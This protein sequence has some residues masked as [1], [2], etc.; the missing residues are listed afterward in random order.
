MPVK[1]ET[2]QGSII[3]RKATFLPETIDLDKRTID[4][5]WST[6][7]TVVRYSWSGRINESLSMDPSAVDLTRLNAGAPLLDAHKSYDLRSQIGVVEKAWIKDGKGYATVR[8]SSRPE[9]E[10]IFRD[11]QDGIIRNISVGYKVLKYKELKRSDDDT[12]NFLAVRWEPMEISFVPVPADAGAQVRSQITFHPVEIERIEEMPRRAEQPEGQEIS[13]PTSPE[14]PKNT[15][16]EPLNRSAEDTP[17]LKD[18]TAQIRSEERKLA[19]EIHSLCDRHGVPDDLRS[20][21]S[22]KSENLDDAKLRILE[23]LEARSEMEA[24]RNPYNIT[25]GR[26]EV[27][28]RREAIPNAIL[29]RQDPASIE[30]TDAGREFRGMTL[31]DMARVCANIPFGRYVDKREVVQRA[32]SSSDFPVLLGETGKRKLLSSYENLVKMQSFKDL[33][34]VRSLPDF[35]ETE[36]VRLSDTPGFTRL[37]EGAEYKFGY[38]DESK[39]G[40]HLITYGR[41][42]GITRQAVIND[43]LGAFNRLGNWGLALARLEAF[44]FW[45]QFN[46]TVVMGDGQELFHTSHQNIETNH[47]LMGLPS[48][49]AISS[50]RV[51]MRRQKSMT[52]KKDRL[53]EHEMGRNLGLV[54]RKILVPPELEEHA[55][56]IV[57]PGLYPAKNEDKNPYQ[58][59]YDIIVG[60]ELIDQNAW[61]MAC[62]KNQGIDLIHMGYLDGN[63]QPYVEY[64]SDFNTDQIVVKT[65]M[66]IACRAKDWK[67]FYKNPGVKPEASG[68][69]D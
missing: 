41:K 16:P 14:E 34:T 2:Q 61:Y 8:F 58:G 18:M 7:A 6:G 27:D 50:A 35:R 68:D 32:F 21:I 29:H 55:L 38:Q 59:F 30:L 40:W 43:D 19:K 39:E 1:K 51:N 44:L 4:V 25:L 66:D 37:P 11:I 17:D 36:D 12:K 62:D 57:M 10:A 20:D 42:M 23:H 26:N 47:D 60:D 9:V 22:E 67:G 3:E 53:V 46:Q 28:V 13:N 45:S 24:T 15:P 54:P 56:K 64:Q 5:C 33:V 31:L 63:Q 52:S 48:I 49:A 69:L 65:R